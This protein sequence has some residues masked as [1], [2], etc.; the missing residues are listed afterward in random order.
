M[1]MANIPDISVVI[2]CYQTGHRIHGFLKKVIHNLETIT[3]NWEIVLVGNYI[4]GRNDDTPLVVKEIA[5]KNSKIKA[6]ALPKQGWMG[7]DART[8]LDQCTGKTIAFI[9]G[10]EQMNAEDIVKAYKLLID[11]QLDIVKPYRKTRD[12]SW[13]RR[14][15]SYIFN[16]I[17]NILFPGYLVLD[18]N[19]KPK[20]FTD[21]AF[22]QLDLKS[23]DWFLDAEIMIHARRLGLRFFE[24]PTSFQRAIYR[25]SFVRFSAALEFIF[26]LLKARIREYTIKR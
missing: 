19:S 20:I 23:D 21:K 7:W 8:G 5:I 9:D 3:T 18:V 10:D 17:Y 16:V 24:F 22:K 13:I 11:F 1:N 6:V 12:D 15:N 25:K 14:V 26:N 2:L 4:E